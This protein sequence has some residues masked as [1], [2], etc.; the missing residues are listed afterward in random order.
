M[1]QQEFIDRFLRMD[2]TA[3]CAAGKTTRVAVLRAAE[4][5][6]PGGAIV[7]DRGKKQIALARMQSLT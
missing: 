4:M 2:T 7:V 6:P 3:M 1:Q 5:A